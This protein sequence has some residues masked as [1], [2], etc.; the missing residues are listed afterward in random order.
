MTLVHLQNKAMLFT[1]RFYLN[2]INRF[3]FHTTTKTT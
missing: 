1:I 3:S 2:Y